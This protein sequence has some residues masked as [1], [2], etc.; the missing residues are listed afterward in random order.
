MRNLRLLLKRQEGITLVMAVGILGCLTL[1][2]ATLVYYSSTNA[3]STEYSMRNA[4]AY[5]L[6]EAGIDEM[7]AVLFK[8]TNNAL[9]KHLLGDNGNGT[10]TKTLHEFENG[11]VEWWGTLDEATATWSIT[12]IGRIRN[13][14]GNISD[15]QRTLTAKVPVTPVTTQPLNNPAWNYVYS[16]RVTG[17]ECDM[18]IGNTVE[19][20]TRVYVAGNLCLENQGKILG[21]PNV[22]VI[23]HGDVKMKTQQTQIG[24]Q[25]AQVAE[26]HIDDGCTWFNNPMHD[27]CRYGAGS[28]GKDNLWAGVITSA[29]Q[30]LPKP[31]ADL[32]AW[33]L[34]ASPG[35][36]YPCSLVHTGTTPTFDND[37]GS[38]T[39]PDPTKRNTS[40]PGVFNLTPSTSY[41]CKT[42][43]GELS[44][45]ASTKVLTVNG[46]IF[47]DGY[48]EVENGATNRYVGQAS[49]YLSGS[50]LIKNSKLCGGVSG[51][52]CDFT[53]WNPNSQMLTFVTNGQ[54][55]QTD[56]SSGIGIEIKSAEFQ[57]ALYATYKVQ[58]DTSSK[59]DGPMVG[60]EVVLGQSI[61]TDDF[62]TIITVPTG[63][64]GNPTVYA[65]PNPPQLYSG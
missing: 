37:Q 31:V 49:I 43:G 10:I 16:T 39:S 48:A 30:P 24:A 51:T 59:A 25:T 22:S 36:Y 11:T 46:T 56:V 6:A 54:G 32:E 33:Y 53:S 2:G 29:P 47:I 64:P 34:N 65:Q 7:M 9:N 18:T 38:A 45:N 35:P 50:L 14:S 40:V 62:P 26:A 63:M 3:R 23:V 52:S 57:G 15:V 42:A 60:E 20:K 41:S 61:D 19:L 58:L 21:S 27:P 12:S 28:A 55:G 17:G 4:S 1:T 13:P 5:D 8:P 44:W